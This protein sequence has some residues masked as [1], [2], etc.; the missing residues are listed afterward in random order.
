[1]KSLYLLILFSLSIYKVYSQQSDCVCSADEDY[2]I[3]L[4]TGLI[5]FEYHN[6]VEG[7][8]GQQYFN[9]WTLGEVMLNN[10]DVIKSIFLRYD[11]YLDELLWF[12]KSDLRTGIVKKDGITGFRLFDDRNNLSASFIKKKIIL[13]LADSTDVFL[14][15]LVSGQVPLYV[16][17]NVNIAS[18]D[19]KLSDNTRYLITASGRD[20][21]ITLKRQ[22]LLD[23]PVIQKTEM[24]NILRTNRITI[25][26]NEP[27]LIRAIVL[28]NST[29][30]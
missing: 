23:I 1:M 9:S 5:G 4:K 8:E 24:K 12:R 28:F 10:G 3:R 6:P 29:Y 19:Y 16:Y 13:P 14:Q 15:V 7:Y 30:K 22:S 17:R 27:G 20:F 25:K 26:D 11:K 18:N 2:G 21:L